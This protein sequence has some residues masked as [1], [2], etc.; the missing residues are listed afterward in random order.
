MPDLNAS[1]ALGAKSNRLLA[2]VEQNRDLCNNFMATLWIIANTAAERGAQMDGI[3]IGEVTMTEGR[4]RAKVGFHSV[5][6]ASRRYISPDGDD[7]ASWVGSEN[8]DLWTFIRANPDIPAWLAAVVEKMDAY[9]RDKGR[10][11]S[12]LQFGPSIMDK[13][14]FLV[15]PIIKE[16]AFG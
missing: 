14:D 15:M 3:E 16:S 10:A 13:D 1:T 2:R 12:G 6:L 11:F 5:S 7:L 8:Q 4:I 9:C